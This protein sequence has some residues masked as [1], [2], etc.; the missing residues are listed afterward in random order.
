[1]SKRRDTRKA[2]YLRLCWFLKKTLRRPN[3]SC[4]SAKVAPGV[5]QQLVEVWLEANFVFKCNQ[6]G[7]NPRFSEGRL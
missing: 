5:G 7:D 1:M 4:L 2:E 6:R 3:A